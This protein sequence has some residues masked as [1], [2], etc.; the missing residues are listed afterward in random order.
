MAD[1]EG[2]LGYYA[3]RLHIEARIM[4]RHMANSIGQVVLVDDEGNVR[5]LLA[6]GEPVIGTQ[7]ALDSAIRKFGDRFH[8]ALRLG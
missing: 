1:G 5:Q 3:V 7:P 6:V 8:D 4:S 2:S